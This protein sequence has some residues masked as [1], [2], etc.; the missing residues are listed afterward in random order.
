MSKENK[1]IIIPHNMAC[2]TPFHSVNITEDAFSGCRI[3]VIH[4]MEGIFSEKS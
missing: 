1:S 3:A 2:T 4:F